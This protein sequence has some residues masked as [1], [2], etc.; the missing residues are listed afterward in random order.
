MQRKKIRR[1]MIGGTIC[2]FSLLAIAGGCKMETGG[3]NSNSNLNANMNANSNSNTGNFNATSENT[4]PTINTHEPDK[5]SSTLVFSIETSGGDKA[6][7]IPSLSVNVARN[8]DDR[9]LE[10][11]LPDGSPLVYVDHENHHYVVLPARKQYAELTQEATGVQMH[12]LLTPGQLVEDLKKIN[13]IQRAGD[14]TINGRTA[15]KY[16]YSA[17][18]D[19]KTKAGEVIANAF[20]YVDKEAGL[21]LRAELLAQS[22]GDVK[23][24]NTARVVAEMRDIN[25]NV[26]PSMFQPPAGYEKVAPE[27]VRQQ[28]DALTGAVTA[29][30]KAMMAGTSATSTPSASTTP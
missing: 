1:R 12:K 14:D 25:T 8:G 29:I 7:G 20:V 11:K 6:V 24:M 10:F 5:Y 28:I 18:A 27:K 17:A 16:Q 19:T 3:T 9:R 13:G 4:G 23:G 22:T 30:L 15:E 21:P 2:L 26:D